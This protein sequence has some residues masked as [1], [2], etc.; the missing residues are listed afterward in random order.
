MFS[1]IIPLYNKAITIERAIASVLAQTERAFE[2]I[3][4]DDGSTDRGA[5]IVRSI[6]DPRIRLIQQANGGVS[7]ARNT[8]IE[9]AQYDYVTFLDADD[10]YLPDCLETYRELIVKYPFAG[11]WA[12]GYRYLDP[13]GKCFEPEIFELPHD[14]EGYLP[15]YF[16]IAA[17][18]SPLIWT[19]AVC[20][21]KTV[22]QDIGMFPVGVTSG[23]DLL[24]W[25]RAVLISG[26]ALTRHC[27]AVY[28]IE[29]VHDSRIKPIP[30][31]A[32]SVNDAVGSALVAEYRNWHYKSD[33][34]EFAEYVS[35]WFKMR[36]A[37]CLRRKHNRSAFFIALR[38]LRFNLKNYKSWIILFL[39]L[40][41][42]VISRKLIQKFG[43]RT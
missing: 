38:S 36:A 10:E 33:K 39:S 25:S 15:H 34:K 8:G 4:V 24:T 2:L 35:F 11:C 28:H 42:S 19:G 9:S 6:P 3:V 43:G 14:F 27:C 22:L 7:K 32:E 37:C 18:S 41:P 30:Q 12:A 17:H 20:L 31:D 5:E 23:E 26:A 21:R 13:D 40:L 16:S 29:Y 1:V